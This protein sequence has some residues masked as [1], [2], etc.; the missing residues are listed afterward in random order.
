MK[1]H[2]V[3]GCRWW[4]LRTP[5]LNPKFK[6]ISHINLLLYKYSSYD[7]RVIFFM[8]KCVYIFLGHPVYDWTYVKH[9]YIF[10][11]MCRPIHI[12]KYI[13]VF[14]VYSIIYISI[15]KHIVMSS[16]KQTRVWNWLETRN[17][18]RGLEYIQSYLRVPCYK[19]SYIKNTH[20]TTNKETLVHNP[21]E[22]ISWNQ[23]NLLKPSGFYT[24][25]QV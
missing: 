3:F 9:K 14:D 11:N 15:F 23:I 2:S 18:W 8:S 19:T 1:I 10:S 5:T 6:D 20:L 17:Y 25:H 4:P 12:W 13:V 22:A 16:I 7:Y 21:L 24:N